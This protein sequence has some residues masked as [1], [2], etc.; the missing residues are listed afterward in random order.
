MFYIEGSTIGFSIT[1]ISGLFTFMFLILNSV[2]YTY[3]K[4]FPLHRLILFFGFYK[5]VKKII[6]SHWKI[7]LI[8]YFTTSKVSNGYKVFI[9]VKSRIDKNIWT[10]DWI[11]IDSKGKIIKTDLVNSINNYDKDYKTEIIQFNRDKKIK[12]IGL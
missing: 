3:T 5:S 9:R 4:V 6:P 2:L 12:N 1:S 10:C 8:G 7:T 11:E